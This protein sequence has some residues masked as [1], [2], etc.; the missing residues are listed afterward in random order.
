MSEDWWKPERL[1]RRR[2]NLAVRSTARNALRAWFESEGFIEVETPALQRSP[3]M[4]PHLA[5]FATRMLPPGGFGATGETGTPRYLHT[6]PEFAMKKLLAGGMERIWQLCPVFR[7]AEGSSLH[8]PEFAMLEWYRTGCDYT[9]LME[10]CAKLLS[11]MAAAASVDEL[12]RGD[13]RCD[14]KATP[15]RLSVADAFGQYCDVDL[16]AIIAEDPEDPPTEALFDAAS[17]LGI[18][19]DR[20]DLFEDVFF[21]IMDEKI[22]PHLG[23]DAPC[24]LYDYPISMAA[25]ARRKPE[26]DLWAERV[27]LYVCGTELANGFS[28]LTDADEQRARF[29]WD[30]A[31]K[32]KLYGVSYPVDE[33]FLQAVSEMPDAAGM[34][35]GFDRLVMLLTGAER[36]GDVL[37]APVE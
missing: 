22:E 26:S 21:R 25:L 5:A 2:G 12:I 20:R 11:S 27:E 10:D 4:E 14:P 15:Q 28:E 18:R 9:V 29:D 13:A 34:A 1:G 3:G 6:S 33:A 24:L 37:W 30:M 19:T 16:A 7:N 32:N 23:M 35:L 17:A 31:L 36:I 8:S